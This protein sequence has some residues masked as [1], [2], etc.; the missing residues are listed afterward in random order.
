MSFLYISTD[1]Y[2]LKFTVDKTDFINVDNADF[3]IL[4]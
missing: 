2:F 1:K 4:R 3:Y